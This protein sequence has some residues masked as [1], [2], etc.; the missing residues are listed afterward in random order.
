MIGVP[1]RNESGRWL[2]AR[3]H[4]PLAAFS[5]INTKVTSP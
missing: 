1:F 2:Y 3:I 4:L 5:G